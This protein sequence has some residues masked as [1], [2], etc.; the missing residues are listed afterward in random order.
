MRRGLRT[1][2]FWPKKIKSTS[3]KRNALFTEMVLMGVREFKLEFAIPGPRWESQILGTWPSCTMAPKLWIRTQEINIYRRPPTL[4]TGG[5]GTRHISDPVQSKQD[6]P[7]TRNPY[8]FP[9]CLTTWF[10]QGEHKLFFV[11]VVFLQH[12]RFRSELDCVDMQV[13]GSRPKAFCA[14]QRPS[15][16]DL[17]FHVQ[18][19]DRLGSFSCS[20]SV[21]CGSHCTFQT[22]NSTHPIDQA[23]NTKL[24]PTS[25]FRWPPWRWLFSCIN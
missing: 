13:Y 17:Y 10:M 1:K 24:N 23:I 14:R 25:R 20:T 2:P 8:T 3:T 19:D 12:P 18:K 11:V 6:Y 16:N 21:K 9:D 4:E 5:Q 15:L 22:G 7:P